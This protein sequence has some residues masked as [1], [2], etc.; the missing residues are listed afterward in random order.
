MTYRFIS[1]PTHCLADCSR[2]QKAF[3][4][5]DVRTDA[6][7]ALPSL[8]PTIR[9]GG[10][11]VYLVCCPRIPGQC[12][13]G[14]LCK[15]SSGGA[16][17][18]AAAVVATWPAV[19][20]LLGAAPAKRKA[21]RARKDAPRRMMHLRGIGGGTELT[22]ASSHHWGGVTAGG[23]G[24]PRNPP[25]KMHYAFGTLRQRTG[26]GGVDAGRRRGG[27]LRMGRNGG[28][29]AGR[30]VARGVVPGQTL[31]QADVAKRISVPDLARLDEAPPGFASGCVTRGFLELGLEHWVQKDDAKS[32]AGAQKAAPATIVGAITA[33]Q[34]S[35]STCWK[36]AGRNSTSAREKLRLSAQANSGRCNMYGMETAVHT[37]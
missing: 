19:R 36:S 25:P 23:D 12:P 2:R 13:P 15:T 3:S 14:K 11:R 1:R 29:S 4:R 22:C 33:R 37:S 21:R 10:A 6:Y 31:G 34:E 32:D 20:T 28:C 35:M 9:H 16:P 5:R 27:C 30:C 24:A 18:F 7:L 17:R 8:G 26:C